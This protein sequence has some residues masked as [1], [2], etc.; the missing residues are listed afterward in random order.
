M[1]QAHCTMLCR[2]VKK[3]GLIISMTA[4]LFITQIW[5]GF[6]IHKDLNFLFFIFLLKCT[7]RKRNHSNNHV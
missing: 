5:N 4:S 1:S 7:Q 3:C 6:A 2:G